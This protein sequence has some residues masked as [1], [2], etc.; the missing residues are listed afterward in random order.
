MK[1]F[2]L[3]YLL[4]AATILPGGA[5]FSQP[6]KDILD[7][8]AFLNRLR[9][10]GVAVKEHGEAEQPFFRVTGRMVNVGGEDVQAF[11]YSEAAAVE[12]EAA[13]VSSDGLTIGN[14]KPHWIGSP[15]FY[16]RGKLLVLYVGED[17]STQ[18][19]LESILGRQF[20]GK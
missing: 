20:A 14:A 18:K 9:E 12:S 5:A 10:S 1:R 2:L 6:R 13:R 8:A 15:H 4:A 17:A 11:Q 16:K 3:C 19:V 7:Y